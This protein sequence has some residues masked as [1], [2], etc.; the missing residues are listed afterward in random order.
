MINSEKDIIQI[1]KAIH[2]VNP[3]FHTLNNNDIANIII[4][5][6]SVKVAVTDIDTEINM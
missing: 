5:I 1:C 4:L 3:D 2:K 6:S